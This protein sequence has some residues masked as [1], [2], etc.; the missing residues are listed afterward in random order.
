MQSFK[1]NQ[2]LFLFQRELTQDKHPELISFGMKID[3]N[4]SQL[5]YA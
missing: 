2:N 1:I 5:A 3:S 4:N